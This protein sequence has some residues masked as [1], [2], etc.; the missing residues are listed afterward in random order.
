MDNNKTNTWRERKKKI[1]LIVAVV[2]F[3]TFFAVAFGL[4]GCTRNQKTITGFEPD[5]SELEG[6]TVGVVKARNAD[7]LLSEYD[8]FKLYRYDTLSQLVVGLGYGQVDI[9][10]L[11]Y[12]NANCVLEA[13]DGLKLGKTV[14][15]ED[16]MAYL[17][18]TLY[19]RELLQELD[20]WIENEWNGSPE[21]AE[22]NSRVNG[23]KAYVP[24]IPEVPEGGRVIDIMYD[25]AGY[26]YEY[27]DTDEIAKGI[28]IEPLCYFAIDKGYTI[29]WIEGEEN[30][31]LA[32]AENA[33]ALLLLLG[34][35]EVFRSDTNARG[36]PFWLSK[37]YLPCKMVTLLV[38]DKSK[39][40]VYRN[41]N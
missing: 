20:E 23:D 32:S 27:I 35:S 38:D 7:Y 29:N 18:N 3:V 30:S 5:L 1:A 21:Q 13:T 25:G 28:A 22:L 34:E 4:G 41:L 2:L 40:Q 33:D 11:D 17:G 10:V 8:G 14:V 19:S 26:P 12:S 39:V 9:A 6:K 24:K 15:C 31:M 36:E 16:G 37:P